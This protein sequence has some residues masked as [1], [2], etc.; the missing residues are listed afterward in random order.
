LLSL[1]CF[2]FSSNIGETAQQKKGLSSNHEVRLSNLG[3]R[4]PFAML[5]MAMAMAMAMEDLWTVVVAAVA[6]VA[7]YVVLFGWPW[8]LTLPPK[9]NATD[10]KAADGAA[11]ESCPY[12]ASVSTVDDN[13]DTALMV[14]CGAGDVDQVMSL[15]R[16]PPPTATA[17]GTPPSKCPF[18][19]GATPFSPSSTT[20]ATAASARPLLLDVNA[21]NWDG[22][23]ALMFAAENGH[24]AVVK[25]LLQG[26]GEHCAT[27]DVA[28]RNKRGWTAWSLAARSGH[29]STVALL[30]QEQ[31]QRSLPAD[32]PPTAVAAATRAIVNQQ[33]RNGC[34]ALI[35]AA[36]QAHREMVAYLLREGADLTLRDAD[37]V[38]ALVRALHRGADG[39]ALDLVQAAVTTLPGPAVADAAADAWLNAQ[40]VDGDTALTVAAAKG[41]TDVVQAL[42]AATG[43][44]TRLH[45][46]AQ[47]AVGYTAL[48][49]ASARGHRDIVQLLRAAGADAAVRNLDGNTADDVAAPTAGDAVVTAAALARA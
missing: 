31:V 23:T 1:D 20:A 36:G 46:D 18:G 14:A 30:L 41:Y 13:G 8:S 33:D 45:L 24:D 3:I 48:M 2:A 21:A 26:P 40:S 34:T 47:D 49:R 7:T 15:L 27:V 9:N 35:S 37:G 5:A 25:A 22:E 10:K 17:D 42:L 28:R 29:L 19:Y 44:G 4:W 6:V 43:G 38:S 12:L 11:K 39:I 16:S 32:A